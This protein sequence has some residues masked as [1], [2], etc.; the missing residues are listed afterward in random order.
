VAKVA[1]WG[2]P[3]PTGDT[4]Q[5]CKFNQIPAAWEVIKFDAEAVKPKN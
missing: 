4:Q 2:Y 3:P 5:N 1:V